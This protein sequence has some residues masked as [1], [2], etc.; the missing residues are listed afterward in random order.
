MPLGDAY[1]AGTDAVLLDMVQRPRAPEPQAPS[2]STW[3]FLK[4]GPRG[5]AAGAAQGIGSTAD[6][7]GAFGQVM[8]SLG[9]E[10]WRMPDPE[11][12]RKQT[13]EARA[14]LEKQGGPDFNSE[15]GR[16]F[17]NVAKDYMPDPV[18]AHG[19]EQAVANLFRLGG[20][21]VAAGAT[22]GPVAGAALVGAEE[23]FTTADELGQQGVDLATRTKVGAVAGAITGASLA[24]PV[25]GQTV[26][27]TVGLALA[28]GPVSFVAQQAATRQILQN[29]DYGALANQYDPFDPVGLTLSTVLPLGF[30]ALAMRAGAR[31]AKAP[32]L[33]GKVDEARPAGAEPA[34]GRP[35]AEAVDAARVNLLRENIEMQRLTPAE[36]LAGAAAHTKAMEQALDQM[37]A[38]E[39]VAVSD[40]VPLAV[41]ARAA[42]DLAPRV[43]RALDEV[44][45]AAKLAEPPVAALAQ[46]PVQAGPAARMGEEMPAGP[47]SKAPDV[48]T[49]E[50][51]AATPAAAAVKLVSESPQ[52]DRAVSEIE[53]ARP[54]MMVRL[55]DMDAPVMLS[56]LMARVREELG[57]DLAEAPLIEAAAACFLR[58]GGG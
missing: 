5:V 20:K 18:T 16:L 1:Q 7:L 4:A 23:G 41:A 36:D 30:G 40:V 19:A 47:A 44:S 58:T 28:G 34:A 22:L 6:I 10:D 9:T 53:T 42:E 27:G 21:A 56:E 43:A 33:V 31:G 14:R 15:A 2:F 38:G 25:A 12:A 13:E 37:A 32:E 48:P 57:R 35:D 54:D 29:A 51:T 52:V 50:A 46:E 26:K 55:D 49:P 11:L 39:R 24:L 17:R 8:G 3:G 45:A